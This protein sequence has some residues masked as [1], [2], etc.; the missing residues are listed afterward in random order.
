MAC[1]ENCQHSRS[2]RLWLRGQGSIEPCKVYSVCKLHSEY[3]SSTDFRRK[4]IGVDLCFRTVTLP[5]DQEMSCEYQK[6][7]EMRM[8]RV[9]NR[10]TENTKRRIGK[11]SPGTIQRFLTWVIGQ[12]KIPFIE[13]QNMGVRAGWL[14]GERKMSLVFC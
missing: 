6:R 5:K 8:G 4:Y 9:F 10:N 7:A 1:L 14:V 2:V 3:D 11:S 13:I 12:R